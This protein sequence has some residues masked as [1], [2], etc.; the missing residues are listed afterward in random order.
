VYLEGSSFN[1]GKLRAW[2]FVQP[3]FVPA[4]S[5]VLTLGVRIGGNAA[6]GLG[7]E[8]TLAAALAEEGRV[9]FETSTPSA[10]LE[11]VSGLPGDQALEVKAYTLVAERR[12]GDGADCLDALAAHLSAEEPL[13]WRL[14]VRE[15]ATH[16]AS[17]ARTNPEAALEQLVAW[18]A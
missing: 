7:D 5:I 4:S 16:L 14:A 18:E 1:P 9:H 12:F 3:L 6:W 17:L 11:L 15:R 10:L 8:S 13:P 2:A